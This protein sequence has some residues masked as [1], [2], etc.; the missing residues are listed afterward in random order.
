MLTEQQ[1]LAMANWAFI[2]ITVHYTGGKHTMYVSPE[3]LTNA[4]RYSFYLILIWIWSLTWVKLSISL[5]LLR[6][7]QSKAWKIGIWT[8]V[9]FLCLSAVAGTLAGLFQCTPIKA[10]WEL[11]IRQASCWESGSLQ[12]AT[13]AV[14]CKHSASQEI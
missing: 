6:I 13:Y 11:E 12:T 9:A 5:M 7:K 10:N 2:V 1:A 4:F 3:N 14:S 8:M